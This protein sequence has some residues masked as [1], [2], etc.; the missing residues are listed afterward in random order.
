MSASVYDEHAE[1]YVDFVDAGL[2]AEEGRTGL[3]LDVVTSCLGERLAG[4]RALDVCCGEGYLGRHLL[5]RG[6][7]EVLGVDISS[8]LIDVARA[9]AASAALTYRVDDA[10]TL[11][12]IPDGAFD[13]AASQLALMDV[14]DHR[15]LFAAVR[16]VL[17]PGGPFVFSVLHPCFQGAPFH[18]RDAP[19]FVFDDAGR[20][21]TFAVRRYA[22]EGY[23]RSGGDGVRGRVGSYH[24]TVSTYVNDLLAAGFTLERLEEPLAGG[25]AATVPLFA[26]V[27]TVL[28]V[29][30]RAA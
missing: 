3:L 12:S 15:A 17:V 9:R 27:P 14:A 19:E 24:R 2:A 26:E 6:A 30:A 1:F 4:A 8:A 5:A 25:N 22:T 13:A 28:V 18:V 11:A 16:R 10:Q 23:W 21:I 7:R 20:P 29:A